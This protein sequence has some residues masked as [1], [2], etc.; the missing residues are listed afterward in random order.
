MLEAQS[1]RIYCSIA[2]KCNLEDSVATISKSHYLAINY[3]VNA[4]QI[5]LV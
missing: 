2:L 1:L 5:C 4:Q 3:K